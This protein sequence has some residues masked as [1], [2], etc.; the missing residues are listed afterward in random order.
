MSQIDPDLRPLR[1]VEQH[2]LASQAAGSAVE[3]ARCLRGLLTAGA[4]FAAGE[5][6]RRLRVEMISGAAARAS[7][8]RAGKAAPGSGMPSPE[9]MF[10]PVREHLIG[11]DAPAGA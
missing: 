1:A 9:Q 5:W 7:Q 8:A 2:R 6:L 11:W 3:L 4:A 10:A